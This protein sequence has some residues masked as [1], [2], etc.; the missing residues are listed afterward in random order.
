MSSHPVVPHTTQ[1]QAGARLPPELAFLALHG[2]PPEL[3]R[4]AA[5][6]A[7]EADVPAVD[8][9]LREGFL[10]EDWFYRALAAELGL[11]FA[12]RFDLGPGVRY[13]ESVRAGLVPLS[14]GGPYRF[15]IA[16]D[17][18]Q[19][20]GLLARRG[21][22]AP[23]LAVTT[24]SLLREAVLATCAE[25][26]AEAAS[27]A[28]WRAQ[29]ALSFRGGLTGG[30]AGAIAAALGGFVAAFWLVPGGAAAWLGA[31]SGLLFLGMITLRLDAARTPAP[32]QPRLPPQRWA[33][34][35]LP[36]YTVIVPLYREMGVFDRL[37]VA[38]DRFD[39]PRAKLDIKIVI[40][41]E[42]AEMRAALRERPPPAHVEVIVAPPGRPR[43]KPRALNVALPLARGE[44]T[45]IYDAE[46]VPAPDQLRLAVDAFARG[47]PDVGCLQGRLVIDNSADSWLTRLFTIEYATLFDVIN[48]GLAAAGLPVPLGGT[49]THFRTAVLRQVRGWDPW[50][51]TEDADLGI[52]LALLGWRVMDLPS[53]TLEEAPAE[54]GAWMRQRTRWM[55]GFMQTCITHSRR[56]A[57]ALRRLGL[58]GFLGALTM[59]FGT[60]MSA[61][62]YPVLAGAAAWALAGGALGRI[63]PVID[64]LGWGVGLVTLLAGALAMLL[65][66]LEALR[67]R[68]WWGL[69]PW[70][71]LLPLYYVLVSVAA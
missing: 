22:I 61:L 20:A 70:V 1:G 55:K 49:T 17:G 52:R 4:R 34:R 40:E 25:P 10:A 66:P 54:L 59:T 41:A 56:P 16:P 9:L 12:A 64:A 42:D 60:V 50:N 13:P 8:A 65:P 23:G 39:Y 47:G 15:A 58:V 26:I 69:L 43:T 6:L 67:R 21:R 30:Q 35:D 63:G 27:L 31:L 5:A 18:R 29:P 57:F 36:V 2:V 51:V 7:R 28:L 68:R 44:L 11:P 62:F 53:S 14:P 19:I 38:L 33:D 32:V 3:L 24:P 71:P 37:L 46:D 48:P 45:V